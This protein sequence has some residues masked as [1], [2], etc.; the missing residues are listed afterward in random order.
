MGDINV[1]GDSGEVDGD[2]GGVNGINGDGSRGNSLSRQGAGIETSILQN[3]S[4]T[5]AVLWNFIWKNT[6]G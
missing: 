4:S 2:G 1:D 6:E 3:W 5:A